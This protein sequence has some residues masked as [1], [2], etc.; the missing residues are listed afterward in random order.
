MVATA[1]VVTACGTRAPSAPPATAASSAATASTRPTI[2]VAAD[3]GARIVASETLTPRS[4]DLTI[5]SPSV[6][7]VAVRLLL[8]ASFGESGATTYPV[9]YMLHGAGGGYTDWTLNT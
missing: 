3:D 9:L 6:G 7:T 5:E 8:P 4:R 2:G 1:A